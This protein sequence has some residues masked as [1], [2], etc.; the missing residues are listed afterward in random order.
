MQIFAAL[1]NLFH[2]LS[3]VVMLIRHGARRIGTQAPDSSLGVQTLGCARAK[4]LLGRD[5]E[6]GRASSNTSA[7]L[8]RAAT[9]NEELKRLARRRPRPELR[10]GAD[11][12]RRERTAQ[13]AAGA[14]RRRA[15]TGSSPR[16]SSR[17]T[18]RS[19]FDSVMLNRGSSSGRRE[20]DMPVV[21]HE[22]IV[23]RIIGVSP[24]TAQVL[25][26]TDELPGRRGPRRRPT[27]RVAG[28]GVGARLR[29]KRSARH[30]SRLRAGDGEAKRPGDDDRTGQLLPAG[31]ERRR[32]RRTQTGSAT[33][34]HEIKV[35]PSGTL[36]LPEKSP[37][38][39]TTRRRAH[40]PPT[41]R[42][43]RE[44]SDKI[45]TLFRSSL[46]T[47]VTCH[48]FYEAED[49]RLC[50]ARRFVVTTPGLVW[51][52]LVFLI[53]RSSSSPIL[54]SGATWCRRSLWASWPG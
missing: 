52:P 18:P 51:S 8:N 10:G 6:R 38:C 37:S 17:A 47:F 39:S 27:R 54:H 21:T 23:G 36:N 20:S 33:S 4:H 28:D 9:E 31:L 22:G 16:G 49:R 40:H 7:S 32:S 25:L 19:G 13:R 29:Q 50:H 1:Q 24:F 48:C 12:A 53:C 35:K 34:P 44:N 26:I 45:K 41:R 11:G 5:R 42:R 15:D 2:R 14:S 43:T 30:E 46:V 3:R